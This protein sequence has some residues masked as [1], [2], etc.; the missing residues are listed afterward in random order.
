MHVAQIIVII[1]LKNDILLKK[2]KHCDNLW[3]EKGKNNAEWW[4]HSMA[5]V[6]GAFYYAFSCI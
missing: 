6:T 1:Y 2:Y 4:E 5:A 3:L